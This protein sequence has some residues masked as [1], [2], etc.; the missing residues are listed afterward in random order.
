MLGWVN[1]L[2]GIVFYVVLYL[3]IYSVLLYYLVKMRLIHAET[4]AHSVTYPYISMMAP[5]IVG[6]LGLALPWFRD[7]FTRLD[8]FFDKVGP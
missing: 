5:K 6:A 4:L 7:I 8:R 3:T 2:G 1:R